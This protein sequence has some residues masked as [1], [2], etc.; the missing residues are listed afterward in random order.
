MTPCAISTKAHTWTRQ[1]TLLLALSLT[2]PSHCPASVPALTGRVTADSPCRPAYVSA[3]SPQWAIAQL[4]NCPELELRYVLT[5]GPGL[6]DDRAKMCAKLLE[7]GGRG[8]CPIGL[9]CDEQTVKPGSTALD[10]QAADLAQSPWVE[11][12]DLGA[13]SGEI[14]EDGVGELVRMA[15]ASEKPLTVRF[16]LFFTVFPSFCHFF[17]Q[18]CHFSIAVSIIWSLFPSL[19]LRRSS[20][21]GRWGTSARRCAA[22]LASRRSCTSWACRAQCTAGTVGGRSIQ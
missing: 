13:Y 10:N 3:T 8:D 9:G 12:Y 18:F 22:S 16:S 21:S 1:P 19:Y 7:I 6:H 2:L 20:R 15:M 11:G 5:A 14:H 17:H 4:L